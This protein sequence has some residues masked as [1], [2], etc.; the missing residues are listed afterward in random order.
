MWRP[1]GLLSRACPAQAPAEIIYVDDDDAA[2][3]NN[4]SSWADAFVYLQDALAVAQPGDEIRVAQGLYR[5]DQSARVPVRHGDGG[6]IGPSG[7]PT[8]VVPTQER[9]GARGRLCRRGCG[10]PRMRVTW[11]G[12]RSILSG[13]LARAMTQISLG[14]GQSSYESRRRTTA[15]TWSR[16]AASDA[17]A[18]LD[19][20]VDSGGGSKAACCNPGGSPRVANCTFRTELRAGDSA[21][22]LSCT[23]GQPTL[24]NCVFQ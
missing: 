23:G 11:D 3:A 15:A 21:E 14:A 16:A 19:G 6:E 10:G 13:D 7:L 4:G 20:F 9:R 24:S 22:R 17:T 1:F 5:P 12:T 8:A 2:G 18:V